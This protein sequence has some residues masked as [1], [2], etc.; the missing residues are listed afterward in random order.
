M[1][2]HVD[3]PI[4]G[5]SDSDFDDIEYLVMGEAYDIHN[6]LGRLCDEDVY[7]D[8]LAHRSVAKGLGSALTEV[9]I[10]VT[11]KSFRKT[12]FL[13]LLANGGAIF[14]LKTA[15]AFTD[16]HRNQVINYLLLCGL[17][18]GKLIN[19]RTESAEGERVLTRLTLEKRRRLNFID[20]DWHP[21]SER[22]RWLKDAVTELLADWGAFLSVSLY[23]EAIV[24]FLGGEE[25]VKTKVDL[26]EDTRVVGKQTMK[27][28]DERTAFEITAITQDVAFYEQH[29]RRLL[30]HTRL[31]AIEWI[32]M[33]HHDI[34]LKTLP[35]Q[36]VRR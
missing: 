11:H 9:P 3:A 29:L 30:R 13:D 28:L 4:R 1:P 21:A 31:D 34:V 6:K 18:H 24:H 19:M 23:T 36:A 10:H 5:I 14:E 35:Q 15:K 26:V 2:I 8:E 32:N 22:G 25:K 33:Q 27:L 16:E 20:R 7:R 17:Q 12:Y